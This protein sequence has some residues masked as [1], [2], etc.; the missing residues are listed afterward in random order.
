MHICV[1]RQLAPNPQPQTWVP[2]W[3][4]LWLAQ[5]LQSLVRALAVRPA[6]EG[7]RF[8]ALTV[9]GLSCCASKG[10]INTARMQTQGY[11]MRHSPRCSQ[12]LLETSR[13]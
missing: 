5:P 13:V 9:Q 6:E 7:R 2:L 3:R 11:N 10:D 12:V 1:P 8:D 4:L